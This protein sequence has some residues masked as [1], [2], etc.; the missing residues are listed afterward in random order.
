[1]NDA[2]STSELSEREDEFLR[3][4]A[5][6]L[7]FVPRVF[8]ADLGREHGLSM[9]EF[10]ALMHL[11]EAHEGRLRMSDLAGESAL[12]LG[13]M[14]RVVKLLE[15]KGLVTRVPSVT[16]RRACEAVLTDLGRARLIEMR[17][18]HV[19]SARLRLFDKLDGIDLEACTAA[20]ARIPHDN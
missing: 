2:A 9:S 20:L 8:A 6:V 17:P 7:V 13:A 12:T 18:V 5:R 15:G 16:D 11:F 1:M 14:T 19:A 3:A 4:L 10:L